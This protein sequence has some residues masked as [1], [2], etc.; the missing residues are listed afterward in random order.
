MK[1][2][3]ILAFAVA[4][5]LG[6][7][8]S[9]SAV[10]I[11][12]SGSMDFTFGFYDNMNLFSSNQDTKVAWA[13]AA[14]PVYPVGNGA[15][16]SSGYNTTR[17]GYAA[18]PGAGTE[19][20]F[21]AWQRV[22]TQIDITASENVRG[23]LFFEI[24]SIAWGNVAAG[25]VGRGSGGAVGTDGVNIETRRA[26]I[27][28]NIPNTDLMFRVG[29]QG[30]ALPAATFVNPVF[31]DDVGAILA[32]YRI[33]DYVS[34]ATFF[35][36]PVDLTAGGDGTAGATNAFNNIGLST[37]DEIDMVGLLVPITVDGVINVTPWA[38]Y[39]VIGTDTVDTA[40]IA[41]LITNA[42]GT[43]IDIA[44]R[45]ILDSDYQFGWWAGAAIEF[46]MLDP[47]TIAMDIIWG[48]VVDDDR[49]HDRAGWYLSGSIAY[50]TPYVTPT[51]IGWWTT[52][53]DG[54]IWNGSERLP[55][56]SG[57]FEPTNFGWN[58]SFG[59][60]IG[61]QNGIMGGDPNGTWGIGIALNDITFV[62]NLSH[63][64]LF[65]V[66]GGTNNPRAMKDKRVFNV[67]NN[68]YYNNPSGIMM[69]YADWAWELDFNTRYQL[70][71]N[72]AVFM[73]SGVFDL[74]RA[75]YAWRTPA[76]YADDTQYNPD[77]VKLWDTDTA[78]KLSFGLR[79]T[80]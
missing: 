74:H 8:F 15:A 17:G 45:A 60:G 2:L 20:T 43:N 71:E 36:R 70:Y 4:L 79:Y 32:S 30:L 69:T 76:N 67:L 78:W 63:Q 49:M 75:A 34:V 24:G 37:N 38:A 7:A 35:A 29:L 47:L 3:M 46:T 41:G 18:G 62:E 26:F 11:T 54:D 25:A 72:L 61:G 10:E 1:R 52:G 13:G 77:S 57:S 5:I 28:F 55:T 16:N 65:A 23:V 51:L 68:P 14:G 40:P 19:D 59:N 21:Q 73:E 31:D 48:A 58:G 6:S 33:N 27:D 44:Q 56:V 64:I 22:R 42:Y 50:A 80:F 9:A 12:A 53:D 66:M 39:A